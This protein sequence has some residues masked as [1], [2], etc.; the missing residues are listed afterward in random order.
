MA[1]GRKRA[2][3]R[4]SPRRWCIPRALL[5]QP[6]E[7]FEGFDV[8]EDFPGRLGGVL[9]Q[10]L[11]DVMLWAQ[12]SD[13]DREG[14]FAPGAAQRR[15]SEVMAAG[16]EPAVE[17]ALTAFAAIL[18]APGATRARV[19]AGA[20]LSISRWA[21]EHGAMGTA[22]GFAHASALA[23]PEDPHAA[24]AA[25]GVALRWGR[26]TTAETWLRRCVGLARRTGEW[27]PY[28]E[29]LV[30]MGVLLMRAGHRETARRY[31][32]KGLNA[33]RRN[34]LR[35]VRA[36]G[37][38]GLLVLEL[39]VGALGEAERISLAALRAYG[40]RRTHDLMQ[41]IAR[42]RIR[43]GHYRRAVETLE[44]IL[45]TRVRPSERV[46]TLA[47][48]AHAAAGAG[49]KTTYHEVSDEAS[50]LFWALFTKRSA[51]EH[52]LTDARLDLLRAA[53]LVGDW[54]RVHLLAGPEAAE[55]CR[56]GLPLEEPLIEDI[57]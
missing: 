56:R 16:A 27:E 9:W 6:D 2:P 43:Q 50:A 53:A 54:P 24:L 20:C 47:V 40:D 52:V 7:P 5:Q 49:D 11:R 51:P 23:R 26:R 13:A 21:E 4:L 30:Q 35:R 14:L 18:E 44:R 38:H 31:F 3:R 32:V 36:A 29:A 45:P 48:L 25:G 12:A 15:L 46:I 41:D 33:A 17:L 34:G 57:S 42:L 37:L 28:A 39:S 1:S 22:L 10:S 8:V 55:R 19:V